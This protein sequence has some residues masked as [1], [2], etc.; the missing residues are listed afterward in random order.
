[1]S[2]W[3]SP[4]QIAT[5]TPEL[6]A[7]LDRLGKSLR[8]PNFFTEMEEDRRRRETE[9][10]HDDAISFGPSW[11]GTSAGWIAWALSGYQSASHKYL[12]Y[13][14][15]VVDNITTANQYGGAMTFSTKTNGATPPSERM[16]ISS[17]VNVGIGMTTPN[18]TLQVAGGV[19]LPLTSQT[20]N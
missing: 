14:G 7:I 10:S 1:M 19:S 13:M 4:I 16:R 18:S 20:A 17:T 9:C 15:M 8:D 6:E 3:S 2:L 5:V 11:V 12:G